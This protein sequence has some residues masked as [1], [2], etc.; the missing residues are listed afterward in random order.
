MMQLPATLPRRIAAL[1]IFV[2]F[3]IAIVSTARLEGQ[4]AS[5]PKR[6][7]DT[8]LRQ[9][10]SAN[11]SAKELR[12]QARKI[13]LTD[14]LHAVGFFLQVMALDLEKAP[15]V[16]NR[17]VL[18]AEASRR[19]PSFTAPRIWLVADD[20]RNER[21][22][23][24]IDGADTVMRLNGE[25]RKLLVPILAPLLANDA[26][27]P[28]LQKKLGS[29]PIWRTELLSEA[30][31]S[32]EYNDRVERLLRANAPPRYAAAMSVERS[33]YLNGLVA[34]GAP[35]RAITVWKSFAPKQNYAAIFDGDFKAKNPVQPFAWSYASDDYSYS[36][37]VVT[38]DSGE[39][40]VRAHHGGDGKI[41]LL[42]QLVALKTGT[43]LLSITMRDGGLAMPETFFWRLRCFDA[44]DAFAS[45]SLGKLAADWQT[46]QMRITVPET[47]CALQYLSL[48]AEDNDG[49]EAEIEVRKVEVR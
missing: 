26:V 33:A 28:L 20:I 46:M 4:A 27:Y 19:Q 2:L 31:K 12:Q 7:S 47:D 1:L 10:V 21:F 14:P 30:I 6:R 45:Q 32:G 9:A 24:A 13:A 29:F 40:L 49:D 37:K 34:Q 15:S 35:V 43:N 41:A 8:A 38:A 44:Q 22:A 48:E 5:S 3:A 39:V 42:T 11:M 16:D 23:K 17:R 25:F 36:E 18:I